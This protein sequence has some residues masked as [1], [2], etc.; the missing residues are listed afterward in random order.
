MLLIIKEKK[1]LTGR[2][3]DARFLALCAAVLTVTPIKQSARF[4]LGALAV[5]ELGPST[6]C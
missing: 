6:R 3:L 1:C 5:D 2:E 4:E